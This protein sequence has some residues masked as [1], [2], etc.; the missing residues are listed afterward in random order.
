MY[1]SLTPIKIKS[2]VS[3]PY[4]YHEEVLVRTNA[5]RLPI[6]QIIGESASAIVRP[7]FETPHLKTKT[8]PQLVP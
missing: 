4:R 5:S 8:L 2:Q 7:P 3:I 6:I 1:N